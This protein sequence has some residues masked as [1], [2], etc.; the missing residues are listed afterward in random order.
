ML[1]IPPTTADQPD[2][3]LTG[4]AVF[5]AL[6]PAIGHPTV[7][8]VGYH[9]ADSEGRVSSPIEQFDSASRCGVSRSGRVYQLAGEPGLGADA[10]YVWARW[11]RIWEATVVRDCTDSVVQEQS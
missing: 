9:A 4:W 6:L 3:T 10:Q 7:H 11:L 2:L 8:F 5:E 1:W